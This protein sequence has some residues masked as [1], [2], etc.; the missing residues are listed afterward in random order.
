MRCLYHPEALCQG[1]PSKCDKAELV[2][3]NGCGHTREPADQDL[4]GACPRCGETNYDR[5]RCEGCPSTLFDEAMATDTGALVRRAIEL[6]WAASKG[7]VT[8]ADINVEE[9]RALQVIDAEREKVKASSSD[10]G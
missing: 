9:F 7:M 3:C 4:P 1:G 10:S 6:D 2:T 5:E 8:L